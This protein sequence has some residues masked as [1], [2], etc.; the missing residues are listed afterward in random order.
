[1]GNLAT[2]GATLGLGSSADDILFGVF[3]AALTET[4]VRFVLP[5]R[6][7]DIGK[8]GH[9]PEFIVRVT[10]R[11]FAR[12]VLTSGNLGL[13]ETYMEG[14]W[15]MEQGRLDRF[16]ATLAVADVDRLI[17][18][19]PRLL[20]RIAAMRVRHALINSTRRV[21]PHYDV[22]ADVYELFSTRRWGTAAAIS[23]R[24]TTRCRRCRR[25]S[26]TACARSCSCVRAIGCSTSAA[27][28]AD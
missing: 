16:I 8:N 20:A 9:D 21:K 5:D 14:G 23:A 4:R 18:R 22:G 17:R 1:M 3:D 6:T 28:G 12:R 13:G 15:V 24:Q 19:D 7:Y 27:G 26:T 25:T 11:R 10:D 2:I